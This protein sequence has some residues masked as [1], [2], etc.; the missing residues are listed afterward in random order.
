[1]LVPLKGDSL[2]LFQYLARSCDIQSSIRYRAERTAI[3]GLSAGTQPR[4]AG[5][6]AEAVARSR[7]RIVYPDLCTL[8]LSRADG[9]TDSYLLDG[10]YIAAAFSGNRASPTL[11]VATPWTRARIFGFDELARKLDAVQQNQIATRGITVFN[12]RQSI[13]EVRQ[14]LSTDMTNVL[15]KT[16]T[17][18]TIADEVQR[19]ARSTL[20]KFIGIKFL[21]NVTTT[22]EGQLSKTLKQLVAAQIISTFTGVTARVSPDDPTAAEVEAYYQPVFPLLYIVVTFNLRS[23]L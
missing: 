17:V 8:S 10:T 5:E 16:P 22:I 12:Q 23:S 11:D 20:D 2:E 18:I 15:T 13:I 3:C 19:Q 1:M 21:S 7:L 6:I 4:A 14:G 9:T